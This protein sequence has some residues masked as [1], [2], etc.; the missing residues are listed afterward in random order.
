MSGKILK[1]VEL[2]EK[3]F[4]RIHQKAGG[5]MVSGT[6][7]YVG[8]DR[9]SDCNESCICGYEINKSIRIIKNNKIV[10]YFALGYRTVSGR[11]CGRE[12]KRIRLFL[13]KTTEYESFKDLQEAIRRPRNNIKALHLLEADKEQPLTCRFELPKVVPL[14]FSPKRLKD[15]TEHEEGLVEI[16]SNCLLKE[17]E[18]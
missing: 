13:Y 12:P 7:Y 6:N 8:Y 9:C 15:K 14:R 18:K 3:T 4:E 2:V 16:L 17:A 11:G 1:S 10:A 5:L